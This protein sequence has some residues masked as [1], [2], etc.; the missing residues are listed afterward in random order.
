MYKGIYVYLSLLDVPVEHLE[1]EGLGE[2]GL[3]LLPH[4]V[5][6]GPAVLEG[7]QALPQ[8]HVLRVVEGLGVRRHL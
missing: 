6:L 3:P 7:T 1:G 4:L 5:D 8:E 2:E